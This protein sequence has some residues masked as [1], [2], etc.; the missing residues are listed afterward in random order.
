MSMNKY[1][2]AI[3]TIHNYYSVVDKIDDKTF[4]IEAHAYAQLEQYEKVMKNHKAKF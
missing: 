4:A 1:Q 3:N 2:K